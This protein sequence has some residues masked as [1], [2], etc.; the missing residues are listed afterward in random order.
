MQLAKNYITKS[1]NKACLNQYLLTKKITLHVVFKQE[2]RVAL[3]RLSE[4]CLQ[5]TMFL[6]N[7]IQVSNNHATTSLAKYKSIVYEI[8]FGDIAVM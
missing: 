5:V 4:F 7:P 3:D 6:N 1:N 8:V 2:G